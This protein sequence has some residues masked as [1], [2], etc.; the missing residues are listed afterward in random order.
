[1]AVTD[2]STLKSWFKRGLKPLAIQFAA[3]MDSYWHKTEDVIPVDNI[4]G[5]GDILAE[6]IDRKEIENITGSIMLERRIPLFMEVDSVNYFIGESMTIYKIECANVA[7]LSINDTD[8]T[9]LPV[10][11]EAGISSSVVEI[12][13]Q[14]R[15]YLQV[16]V[17]RSGVDAR[18]DVFM[19]AKAKVE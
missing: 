2:R 6:K 18:A 5:L 16:T 13:T 11:G 19:Y 1:M 3:W 15:Q 14:P 12:E 4:D 10:A 8:V 17:T 7:T 9:L